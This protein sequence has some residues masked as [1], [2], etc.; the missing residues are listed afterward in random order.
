MRKPNRPLLATIYAAIS[1]CASITL[2]ACL[3]PVKVPPVE[4]PANTVEWMAPRRLPGPTRKFPT[5][6]ILEYQI[7]WNGLPCADLRTEI[8]AKERESR[9][10]VLLSYRA[11]T[12]S[13]VDWA[14]EFRTAGKTW[15]TPDTLLPRLSYRATRENEEWER[16]WTTFCRASRR[17]THT[18]VE[19]DDETP[20]IE[21]MHFLHGLDI[22]A[23]FLMVRA[24]DL[25]S[26]GARVLEVAHEDQMYAVTIVPDGEEQL[27][28]PAGK[29]SA[30]RLDVGIRAV[31]G[32]EEA[33][34]A[35][36][37]RYQRV[38]IWLS[39]AN[40]LPVKLDAEVF[41]GRITMDLASVRR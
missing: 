14:W 28:L 32:D 9:K 20:D 40:R 21:Q 38:R 4:N 16:A 25:K 12:G 5:T 37:Q 22:P 3:F 27:D 35:E 29:F 11:S 1:A 6:E 39:T 7:S 31:L 26:P 33:K 30:L 15:L 36:N 10:N 23:A 13:A 18:T 2:L 41:V 8:Q 19:T 24:L 17:V 34:Q